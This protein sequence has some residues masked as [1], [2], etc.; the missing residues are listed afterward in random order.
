MVLAVPWYWARGTKYPPLCPHIFN[1]HF[2]PYLRWWSIRSLRVKCRINGLKQSRVAEGLEQALDRTL[3]EQL[4][5]HSL[6][7]AGGDEDD[8]NPVPAKLQ[9]PLKVGSAHPRH[10]DVEDQALGLAD[11]IGGEELF[12]RR[13]GADC[14]A[15]L[16]HQV[17]QRLA[18]RFVVVND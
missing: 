5:A 18:H 11:A 2:N 15:E 13:E 8:R 12:R 6:V 16:L 1:P 17:G 14:K 9:F 4:R 10:G 7:C 3:F